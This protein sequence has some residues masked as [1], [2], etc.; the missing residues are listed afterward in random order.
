MHIALYRHAK[1][2][3]IA[4]IS[5]P[6]HHI[7]GGAVVQCHGLHS[8]SPLSPHSQ[9]FRCLVTDLE[10]HVLHSPLPSLCSSSHHSFSSSPSRSEAG[11]PSGEGAAAET[12]RHVCHHRHPPPRPHCLLIAVAMEITIKNYQCLLLVCVTCYHHK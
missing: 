4:T 9:C 10:V 3:A 12:G 1:L 11:E 8:L 5:D 2:V 7:M 6:T